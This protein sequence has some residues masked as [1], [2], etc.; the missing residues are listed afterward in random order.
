[1]APPLEAADARARAKLAELSLDEKL[2]LLD[3][4]WPFWTGIR[5][6]GVVDGYHEH[7]WNAGVLPER[8]IGG[9]RFIDG[10][11]GIVLEGGAT[12]FPVPMARGACFDPELEERIGDAI[13]RELVALG[14]NLY[15]GVCI[16]LLR[17]PAWGRAQETYGEDPL[18]LGA[19][20]SALTRGVQRH[21]M[22]CVKHF[23]LNSMENA[24]FQVDVRIAPRPLHELY[25][26]HFREV[27]EAGVAS[28]MSAYNS[29]N[30]EWCGQNR[31]LL[32]GILKE[33]WGFEGFVLTDFVMG[34]RDA[35]AGILAGQD[36]E[37][38]FQMHFHL[39]LRRLVDAGEVPL[40]R[41][42]DAALR[43][44]RQQI[45]LGSKTEMS[46]EV[47]GCAEHRALAREAARKSI[48]LLKN[49][50]DL[51]PL[52]AAS[53]ERIAL[54]GRLAAL[55]NLG[56][57]G[58]SDGR[59]EHV[60]TPLEGLRAAL[61][62]PGRLRHDDGA[63]LDAARA[64]AADSDVALVVVGHTYRDEGEYLVPPDFGPFAHGIPKPGPLRWLFA[65]RFMRKL[66]AGL[67]GL[68][69][70]L[71]R[72]RSAKTGFDASV[73]GDRA[74]LAL[75][76]EDEAL[77][78]AVAR[79][80]PRTLVLV[81]AGS[82]VL[83]EAWRHEVPA[84]ALL[85]YP[86]MEGGH[87]L[88]DVLFGS[89]APSGRLPLAVPRHAAD[90]PFFDS[91]ATSVEY[92][93]WHG[94]RKL[95]RDGV[96]AAFPFGF[97]LSTT[98]F[99]YRGLRAS[100]L[101]PGPDDEIALEVDVENTGGR[102][103]DEVVQLYASAPGSAVERPKCWLV[104]F[105]RLSVPAGET[106]TARLALSTRRLAYFDEA[107]DDFHVEPIAYELIAARH[108]ADAE[109]PSL[110]IRVSAANPA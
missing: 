106:R 82:A 17:H 37:M 32:T 56:D 110:S 102:D 79:A 90:L 49:D 66:W 8:G 65:P 10:P 81:M 105:A 33:R 99:A 40:A 43:I 93:L 4:D 75:S 12:T 34:L 47:L 76:T 67:F 58:S 9:V 89:A 20:G 109:G 26:P 42:D 72:R 68:M 63:D 104:G 25:L 36:L 96:E 86:G 39:S 51:L 98:T 70:K 103:A 95:D 11:R 16:N 53:G 80:N 84:I 55:P 94:Q 29:V 62:E 91:E 7:P 54:F 19:L 44:L 18:L 48:V 108:A 57:R 71:A 30:G 107:R 87:G 85:W 13:G 23:A 3:G 28:V 15:G 100:T 46:R 59:P 52:D 38:P 97:G 69:P 6:L 88:A 92:D 21:A 83:M 24:R 41:I 78:R 27:V 77:I 64:L 73:G 101:E 60:V 5:E 1:M 35:R 31:E 2:S 61:A 50:G 45:A 74:R 22:A 14:G